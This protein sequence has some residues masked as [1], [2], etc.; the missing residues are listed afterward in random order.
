MPKFQ[1]I[2]DGHTLIQTSKS[3]KEKVKVVQGEIVD[4][5]DGIFSDGRLMLAG[6]QKVIDGLEDVVEGAVGVAKTISNAVTGENA[7]ETTPEETS[8]Q[9]KVEYDGEDEISV[10]IETPKLT[11][12]QIIEQLKELGVEFRPVGSKTEDLEKLLEESRK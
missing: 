11:R 7:P 2:G 5:E 1:Y 10:E 3:S 12:A 9:T 8:V 4:V 6:F